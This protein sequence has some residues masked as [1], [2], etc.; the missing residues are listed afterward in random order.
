MSELPDLVDIL[1]DGPLGEPTPPKIVEIYRY[2]K[3]MD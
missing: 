3:Q 2:E 1:M